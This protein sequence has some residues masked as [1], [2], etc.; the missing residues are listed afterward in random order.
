MRPPSA[1]IVLAVF[2]LALP[3]FALRLEPVRNDYN[4]PRPVVDIE[5]A[6]HGVVSQL[7]VMPGETMKLDSKEIPVAGAGFYQAMP[8]E[9]YY[10]TIL[11]KLQFPR[12][13]ANLCP[14]LLHVD[15]IGWSR[16]GTLTTIVGLRPFLQ[17]TTG[18]KIPILSDVNH[19]RMDQGR[20]Y[21]KLQGHGGGD[22]WVLTRYGQVVEVGGPWGIWE[23]IVFLITRVLPIVLA[24]AFV[25]SVAGGIVYYRADAHPGKSFIELMLLSLRHPPFFRRK[26]PAAESSE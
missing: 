11:P 5:D 7:F 26:S 14:C 25:Y 21:F 18:A 19:P 6:D 2:S 17:T 3:A 20:L 23:M 24:I 15:K 8:G 16:D 13:E 4:Y 22:Y 12:L 10:I 1:L 9:V